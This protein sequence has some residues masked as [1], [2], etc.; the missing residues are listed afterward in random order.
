MS[1]YAP[2]AERE[3]DEKDAFYSDLD[4]LTKK[5]GGAKPMIIMGDF[6]AR[7]HGRYESEEQTLGT[8]IYGRGTEYLRTTSDK[9]RKTAKSSCTGREV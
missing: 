3:E 8:H 6:S 7:L 5:A 9:P 4:K 2:Q 1:G